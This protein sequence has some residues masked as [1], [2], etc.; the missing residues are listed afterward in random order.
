D[1]MDATIPCLVSDL[2]VKEERL[3]VILPRN[4]TERR[5]MFLSNID[6]KFVHYIQQYVHFFSAHPQIPFGMVVDVQTEAL[7]RILDSYDFISGRL[8]FNSEEGRFEIDSNAAGAPVAVCSSELSLEDLGDVSYPNP[9][10]TQLC[11]LSDS[12]NR[13]LEDDPLISFQITRFRCGGFALGTALNH[14]VMD[15]FPLQEF[16]RNFTNMVTKGELAFV[17]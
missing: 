3:T 1:P 14:S 9:A 12:A 5:T 10:F 16:A 4:V 11:L 8:R 7:S 2:R 13:I 17:P 15:G 6:Q